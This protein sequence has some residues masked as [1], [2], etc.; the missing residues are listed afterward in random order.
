MRRLQVPP[1]R[2]G[3]LLQLAT[4]LG[5]HVANLRGKGAANVREKGRS[6]A[7]VALALDVVDDALPLAAH[8]ARSSSPVILLQFC[9]AGRLELAPLGL[10]VILSREKVRHLL[11]SINTD[12]RF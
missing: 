3:L 12:L 4:P 7:H 10:G 6:G 9:N 2:I 1:Q 11:T 5:I 8:L